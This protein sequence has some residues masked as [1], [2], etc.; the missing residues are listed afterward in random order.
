MIYWSTFS[1]EAFATLTTGLVAVVGAVGVALGQMK[2]S[3]RQTEILSRQAASAEAAIR[4]ELFERRLVV[5]EATKALLAHI[6]T[7][8]NAP[9]RELESAFLFAKG[10]AEFLFRLNIRNKLQ[11]I[12]ENVVS[13]TSENRQMAVNFAATQSYGE[14]DLIEREHLLLIEITETYTNIHKIFG[15]EMRM[16]DLD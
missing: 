3:S 14:Q 16:S 5:Y 8:A 11:N 2:I 13:F 6:M 1:W 10:D 15:A 12:W 4:V 9:T 7:H